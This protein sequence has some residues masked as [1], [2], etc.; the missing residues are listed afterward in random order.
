[1]LD[2][3]DSTN[4]FISKSNQIKRHK[5]VKIE[6]RQMQYQKRKKETFQ[7]KN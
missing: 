6:K 5:P 7:T 1:M 2:P 4:N 3:L